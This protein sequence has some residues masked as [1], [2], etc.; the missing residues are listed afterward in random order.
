MDETLPSTAIY[1]GNIVEE[2][3]FFLGDFSREGG[4]TVGS[5]AFI[6]DGNATKQVKKEAGG[7]GVLE[8]KLAE[9]KNQCR[10][11]IYFYGHRPIMGLVYKMRVRVKGQGIV[12]FGMN[13]QVDFTEYGTTDFEEITL[14]DDWQTVEETLDLSALAPDR[15]SLHLTLSGEKAILMLTGLKIWLDRDAETTIVPEAGCPVLPENALVPPQT[16]KVY[17][18]NLSGHFVHCFPNGTS[19]TLPATAENGIVTYPA[20]TL[21]PGLHRVGFAANGNSDFRDFLSA[22]EETIARLQAAAAKIVLSKDENWLLLGDSLSDFARKH[23]H[24]DIATYFINQANPKFKLTFRNAACGGD[25]AGRID[26][27]LFKGSDVFRSY[28]YDGL[29]DT[30][31]DRVCVYLLGNDT[32]TFKATNFTLPQFPPEFTDAKLRH[33]LPYVQKKS[34]GATMTISSGISMPIEV[35]DRNAPAYGYKFGVPALVEQYNATV[36][37]IADDFS[38]DYFDI[39]TPTLALKENKA[40]YFRPDGTHL[41]ELGHLFVAEKEMEFFAS[42]R[43]S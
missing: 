35:N 24:V 3:I 9:G 23:N 34:G 25:Q 33:F 2:N 15:L 40:Q 38:Y 37:R 42:A 28:M 20:F 39:Y 4:Y 6:L 41:S 1:H 26:A 13:P 43:I 29:F 31:Y 19:T 10:S 12:R 8:I 36:R 27:R 30:V 21:T 18:P 32:V 16:F 5:G 11:M 14:T 7:T 17:P 22:D